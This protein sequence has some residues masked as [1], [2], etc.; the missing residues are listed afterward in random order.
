MMTEVQQTLP[1]TLEGTVTSDRM[2]K[3][4]VVAVNRMT[5]HSKYKKYI[6]KTTK[7]HAHDPNN[8]A[9]AGDVVVIRECRPIAKTVCWSLVKIKSHE[10]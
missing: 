2:N 6:R 1:R 7:V 3:T 10:E 5:K 9:K 4:I 8:E